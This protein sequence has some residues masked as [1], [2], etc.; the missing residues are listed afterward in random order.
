MALSNSQLAQLRTCLQ[1]DGNDI[2]DINGRMPAQLKQHLLDAEAD[3]VQLKTRMQA[4]EA[5]INQLKNRVVS[6]EA[7]VTAL[8]GP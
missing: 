3:I 2:T 1:G 4:A 7:R 5:D 6:L 8:E